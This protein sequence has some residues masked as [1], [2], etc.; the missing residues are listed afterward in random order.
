[1]SIN[2]FFSFKAMVKLKEIGQWGRGQG[3]VGVCVGGGG[4]GG[5]HKNENSEITTIVT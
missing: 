1:M 5:N 3:V 4:G 2:I